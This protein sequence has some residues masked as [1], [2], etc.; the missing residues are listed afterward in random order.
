[1]GDLMHGK[2]G[3][4]MGLANDKSIAYGMTKALIDQ[5]ADVALSYQGEALLK[6]V[7]PMAADLGID[8]FF[9]CDVTDEAAMDATFAAIG[10]TWGSL[11]FLVHAIGFSDKAELRG[12]YVDTSRANFLNTMDISCFSFTAVAKRAAALMHQGGAMV[13]LTYQGSERV[14]PNYNVMG[15]AKAAL[16]AS[17]MYLA[18]DLG[19]QGIR[20]NALSAGPIRTLAA[21]GIGD[22]KTMLKFNELVA[23]LRRNIS[24]D[25]VGQTGLYLLSD[26]S[27]GVT[28][29]THHVDSGYNVVGMP[30][31]DEAE[32]LGALYAGQAN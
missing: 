7:Q 31:F 20:V 28:G 14:V 1:M 2:R 9:E 27:S 8:Q 13:T 32:A 18:N 3:L 11:D 30:G 6:R 21:S 23:P 22:F 26:M 25:E 12:A 4:V 24:I 16:E 10:K 5:G 17:V 15:V 29:E 19:P